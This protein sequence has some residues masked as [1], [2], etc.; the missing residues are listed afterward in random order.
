MRGARAP[1]DGIEVTAQRRFFTT[2]VTVAG[3]EF[4]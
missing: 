3:I 4:T 1:S 2:L